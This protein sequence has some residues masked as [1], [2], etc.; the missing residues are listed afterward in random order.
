MID[1][2]HPDDAPRPAPRRRRIQDEFPPFNPADAPRMG[3]D[4]AKPPAEP[5]RE[6]G[7]PFDG[8]RDKPER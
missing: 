8:G 5:T 1:S 4:R 6:H 7:E 2:K 3:G